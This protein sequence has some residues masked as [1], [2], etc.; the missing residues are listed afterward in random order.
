MWGCSGAL[1]FHLNGSWASWGTITRAVTLPSAPLICKPSDKNGGGVKQ[2]SDKS[3]FAGRGAT[4]AS[5][6]K[7]CV[8]S[9]ALT[10][11]DLAAGLP[12]VGGGVEEVDVHVHGA[13]EKGIVLDVHEEGGV[14]GHGLGLARHLEWEREWYEQH[15]TTRFER[16]WSSEEFEADHEGDGSC[17]PGWRG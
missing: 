10:H 12:G 7:A 15:I 17:L 2:P 9:R 3:E 6:G 5:Y 11:R 13:L 16:N 1:T 14:E 8:A 4:M